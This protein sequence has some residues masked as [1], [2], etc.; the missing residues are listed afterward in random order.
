MSEGASPPPTLGATILWPLTLV[1]AVH[2]LTTPGQWILTDQAEYILVADRLVGRGTLHLS[3]PGEGP[4]KELPWVAPAPPGEPQRSRLLPLTSVALAPFVLADRALGSTRPPADR[5][6]VQLQG[7]VFVLAALALLGLTLAHRR[8]RASA[9]A[10]AV[11]LTGLAWPIWQASRRGGAEA[12]FVFL[13]ALFVL[14]H[15]RA[16]NGAPAGRGGI[17]LMA[18][19]CALLPWGNPTGAILAGALLAGAAAERAWTGQRVRALAVP[20]L[21]WAAASGALVVLW[22]HGYHGH[23]WLG[24]YAPHYGAPRSIVDAAAL[25]H[26]IALHLRA[27]V[28]EG[29]PLLA[30]AGAGAFLGSRRERAALLPPLALVL[31]M[32]VLFATF[33]QPE[34]TRRLAAA[35]PAWGAAAGRSLDRPSWTPTM[36]QALL[37]LAAVVGFHGFWVTEGRYHEGPGGLFYPSV[38]WV[39]LWIASAPAWQFALPCAVLLVLIVV[40]AGR[41]S[42]LLAVDDP[43]HG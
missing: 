3:E 10:A 17:L 2:L 18:A 9:I 38:A 14:G 27:A 32:L 6:L 15:A 30:V 1:A 21:A 36:R 16:G 42:R 41:T 23:W 20:A 34:P 22:N 35:W 19:A 5:P 26:G 11:V 8:A 28:L 40:A 4:R 37:A 29:G 7:H 33:P 24:G 43:V 39:R 12:L 31:A 13:V 25:P